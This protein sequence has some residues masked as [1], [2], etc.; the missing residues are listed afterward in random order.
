MRSALMKRCVRAMAL[1]AVMASVFFDGSRLGLAV[2]AATGC[3]TD[4]RVLV[5][6]ADGNEADLPAITTTFDYLGTPYTLY[7]ANKTPGGLT[8]DRLS[9]GCHANY[10]AVIVTLGAVDNAWSGILTPTELQALHTFESQFKLRQVVWYTYPNDFGL[11]ANGPAV[12][13]IGATPLTVS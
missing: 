1:A 11:V 12:S 7:V 2:A 9:S 10:Q 6:A 5:I 13:T 8:A 3:E 4:M